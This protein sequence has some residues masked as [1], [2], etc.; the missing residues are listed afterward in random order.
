[1]GKVLEV[2]EKVVEV[3]SRRETYSEKEVYM[4]LVK[5]ELVKVEE[6]L[7]W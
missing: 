7:A 5:E 1:M 2:E 3:R 4:V 6:E